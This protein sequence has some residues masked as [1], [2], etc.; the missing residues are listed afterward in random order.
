MKHTNIIITVF[1]L[2]ATFTLAAQSNYSP[3]YT[4]NMSKGNT[5]FSQGKYSEAKTYYATAKQCAGGNPTEAQKK[6]AACDAKIKAQKEAAENR[7]TTAN[8]STPSTQE[9][10]CPSSVKDYDGNTYKTVYIGT[11]CWMAE[12]LR[13]TH[14]T[15][16][17]AIPKAQGTKSDNYAPY[18]YYPNDDVSNVSTYGLLYNWRGAMGDNYSSNLIPSGV[19]GICPEGWHLPSDTEWTLLTD[20]L[21]SAAQYSCDNDIK[22]IAKSLA[23][24]KEWEYSPNSCNVGNMMYTNNSSGFSALPSGVKS[25]GRYDY[26]G[27]KCY[28]WT[29]TAQEEGHAY[30]RDISSNSSK[31]GLSASYSVGHFSHGLSIRCLRNPISYTDK[32]DMNEEIESNRLNSLACQSQKEVIDCDGNRYRTVQIGGQCWMAENLRATHYAN[33]IALT[34]GF[35]DNSSKD[36]ALFDY[37]HGDSSLAKTFGLLY[38]WKAIMGNSSSSAQNP[39]RVQGLCPN[40]WHVPSKVEW[41]MLEQYVNNNEKLSENKYNT[42][43]AYASKRYWWYYYSKKGYN[44]CVGGSPSSNNT[45]GFSVIPAGEYY[46]GSNGFGNFGGCAYLWSSTEYDDNKSAYYWQLSH[47]GSNPKIGYSSKVNGKSLRCVKN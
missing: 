3:C 26:F 32:S 18:Y 21:S 16:G 14:Y 29:S 15:N 13:A 35:R 45:T 24:D 19:R 41:E 1:L 25:S 5:A 42:G 47:S 23:A 40:G 30:T 33:G 34:K 39:S 22:K 46:Y 31:V 8:S 36:I 4:N 38:N 9:K 43:K 7:T 2:F 12:N 27:E 37:P 28:F 17:S 11:Q 6:I 20:F 44:S 10:L